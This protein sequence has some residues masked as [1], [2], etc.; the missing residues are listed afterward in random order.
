MQ[1]MWLSGPT[2]RIKTISITSATIIRAAL[3]LAIFLVVMGFLLNLLGLRIA[4]EHSPELARSLGGVTTESE[5]IR[6]ESIY[7]EKLDRMNVDLQGTI[8]ELKQLESI[9][10]KF[11][12]IA[13]PPGFKEKGT[14][15]TDSLGGPFVPLDLKTSFFRQPL[16]VAFKNA[17]QDVD[18]LKTVVVTMQTQWT[19]QL[20]WLHAL[21]LGIP[22]GGEFRYTS[23]FG[24][25]NDPFTGQLAMHEGIDFSAESGTPVLASADGVVIR[26]GWDASFGNVIEVRHAE[27]YVTRYA[28]LR[29]RIVSEGD[30]IERGT[31]LGEVGSTGRSTGPH[32][33]YEMFRNGRLINPIQIIP[34]TSG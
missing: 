14:Q 19:D 21:P 33:H 28:H 16:D 27:D 30:R 23:G 29:K 10:N 17:E 34:V 31:P 6:M 13:S 5:Q 7:R 9:K 32:L 18:R 11:M 22:V 4:V 24:I 20:K 26:S 8:R 25:R 15:K 3:G 1:L 12:E 2:G